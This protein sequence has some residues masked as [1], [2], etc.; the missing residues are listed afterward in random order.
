MSSREF[1]D[2][3][4]QGPVFYSVDGRRVTFREAQW[5]APGPVGAIAWAILKLFGHR[6]NTSTD[7]PPVESLEPHR[8][9]DEPTIAAM[10]ARFD[11]PIQAMIAMGFHSPVFHAIDDAAHATVNMTVTLAH[12]SHPIVARLRNRV[13][14][15]TA[16]PKNKFYVEFITAFSDGYIW[17][18][19][20]QA[21]MLA[22][23]SCR[24][25]RKKGL[26]AAALL[27]L[28]KQ[29]VSAEPVGRRPMP[30]AT[31][32]QAVA[33]GDR[34][35]SELREFHRAR[36][37]FTELSVLDRQRIEQTRQSRAA[38]SAAGA[39]RVDVQAE[40]DRLQN[41]S[42]G[43]V[44][45]VLLLVIS[46]LAFLAIG[47]R[48][49]SAWQVLAMV[50][51]LLF[52]EAGHY[53]AMKLFG[54]RNL[55]MFFIPGLGAAVTG[56]NYNV[57][58]WKKVIVFLMGPV[59]GIV[60]GIALGL[61]GVF[62][63]SDFAVKAAMLTLV[64]NGFNLLPIMPL[65]GGHVAHLL[66]FSRH[67]VLDVAFRSLAALAM[68]VLAAASGSALLI[69]FVVAMFAGLP[70]SYRVC[71][72]VSELRKEGVAAESADSQTIPPLLVDRISD[73][74]QALSKRP[75]PVKAL[76]MQTLS[77]FE[78][79]NARPP[80]LGGTIGLLSVHALSFVAALVF[81]IGFLINQNGALRGLMRSAA[82][83]PK[84]EVVLADA[85][86][87]AG[88]SAAAADR[89]AVVATFA[90]AEDARSAKARHEADAA[91]GESLTVF[92][93]TLYVRFPA[94]DDA[95]R[96]RWVE[97]LQPIAAETFVENRRRETRFRMQA[98]APSVAAAKAL[99]EDAHAYFRL[100]MKGR[101]IAPWSPALS[102]TPEQMRARRTYVQMSE[103]EQAMWDDPRYEEL[104]EKEEAAAQTGDEAAAERHRTEIEAL[105]RSLRDQAFAVITA[106]S[107][108]EV[109]H[110]LARRYIE[111][112]SDS[113]DATRY[114]RLNKAFGPEFGQVAPAGSPAADRTYAIAG[115]VNNRGLVV[116][117]YMLQFG[118]A[119]EGADAFSRWLTSRGC[120]NLRYE[121]MA[122]AALPDTDDE[123]MSPEKGPP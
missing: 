27:E 57:A 21:D 92:G 89:Y 14:S 59:P 120:S 94:D 98:I 77:V 1:S 5:G 60:I 90:R 3:A 73:R 41:R 114:V 70:M 34:L 12:R 69:G 8:A 54:Y 122:M 30:A 9:N 75:Q 39:R 104:I 22:P 29:A 33:I 50:P 101:L 96:K 99:A 82:E 115:W 19:N 15:L 64:L 56:R 109:D 113:D 38:A 16:P 84:Y 26:E 118:D 35:H 95:A 81:S 74:L 36:G 79:L 93:N 31:E 10:Q 40:I 67:F 32:Q 55:R 43:W 76:A 23:P 47:I 52:H 83:R 2:A 97:R 78:S 116:E 121:I 68:L 37:V 63:K 86:P 62:L 108:E 117:A 112:V 102:P 28:H 58:G 51:I 110:E 25:N 119:V 72:V 87:T 107:A 61:C 18:S 111:I 53:F 66:L 71:K 106:R 45:A 100:P 44:G 17:S 88:T 85:V 46:L 4:G 80:G 123:D 103:A 20:G 91:A 6:L 42:S 13:W 11:E 48:G 7:D 105:G 65:D 49:L 24:M